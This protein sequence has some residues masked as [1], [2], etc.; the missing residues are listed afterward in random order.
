MHLPPAL[1]ATLLLLGST[2]AATG[3]AARQ[4][5]EDWA[6]RSRALAD[7]LT[8]ELKAELGA[9][10]QSG[11]PVA[12]IEVCRTRA[13]A[14]AARLSSASGATVGRTAL[15]VRNPANTADDVSRVVLERFA[16][17]MPGPATAPAAAPP[18]AR[19][20]MHT[21]RGVELRY[22]RA[23]PMQPACVTCHGKALAPELQEALRQ[24]YPQDAA[25]GFEPGELRGAV[26]VRWLDGG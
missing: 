2:A 14:I 18:E 10:M 15:R 3:P 1:A 5:P 9:A 13:P 20:E 11:G 7:Q 25:T 22:L 8:T 6:E 19:L 23:I 24:A 17:E 21:A 4:T 16:A 26:V 12:A